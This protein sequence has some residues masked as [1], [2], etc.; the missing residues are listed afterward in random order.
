MLS[1]MMK[2]IKI[3]ETNA[4]IGETDY[5]VARSGKTLFFVRPAGNLILFCTAGTETPL[6]FLIE[7][8]SQVVSELSKLGA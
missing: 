6:S 1:R 8:T 3:I 7:K 2:A 4:G 5:V